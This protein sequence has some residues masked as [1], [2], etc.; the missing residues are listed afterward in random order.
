M[1]NDCTENEE[2]AAKVI[3]EFEEIISNKKSDI[4]WLAYYQGKIF[5]KFKPKEGFVNDMVTKF[6]V[7]K[8]T[9]VFKFAWCKLIDE[10]PK[11]KNSSLSLHYF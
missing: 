4:V 7:S 2:D 5:Q 3:H 10:Y 8:S 1:I 11:T 6:K 9:L